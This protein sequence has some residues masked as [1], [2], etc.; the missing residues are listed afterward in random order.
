MKFED[1]VSLILAIMEDKIIDKTKYKEVMIIISLTFKGLTLAEIFEIT[2]INQEEWNLLLCFFKSYFNLYKG[3]W[4][5]NSDPVKKAIHERYLYDEDGRLKRT[6]EGKLLIHEYHYKLGKLLEKTPNSIRKLEEQTINFFYAQEYH[7]LKHTITD[8]E[9]FL[10]LFNPNTKYDLCRYWQCL[11]QQG[12]DPVIEYNKRLELFDIHYAPKPEELFMIILQISRFFKEF[13]DFETFDTPLFKHPYIKGRLMQQLQKKGEE[14]GNADIMS[15]LIKSSPG[16]S[17]ADFRQ[18]YREGTIEWVFRQND[19]DEDRLDN[20]LE[21]LNTLRKKEHDGNMISNLEDIG[22]EIELEKM[23]MGEDYEEEELSSKEARDKQSQIM[24]ERSSK[25]A[26]ED[27]RL[28]RSKSTERSSP[29]KDI[30]EVKKNLLGQSKHKK[31][32]K[33]PAKN[34]KDQSSRVK[35]TPLSGHELLNIIIP[36]AKVFFSHQIEFVNHF[37]QELEKKKQK[38]NRF[39]K[40]DSS[41]P[42]E[43]ISRIKVNS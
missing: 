19:E 18:E 22:L 2:G 28:E 23:R 9:N 26:A 15:F 42:P 1:V 33:K 10:I 5:L 21:M 38:R 3:L 41:V 12:Y 8:I 27:R 40:E 24:G 31:N 14:D 25:K 20:Q 36:H 16:L 32:K 37:K 39:T 30:N 13:A 43:D 29:A 17:A 6:P 35:S 7:E 34:T 11:E 4:T